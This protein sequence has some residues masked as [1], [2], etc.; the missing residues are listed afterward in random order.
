[1]LISGGGVSLATFVGDVSNETGVLIDVIV[2]DLFL[3]IGKVDPVAALDFVAITIL[4]LAHIS[5][6][7]VIINVPAEFV[8]SGML[9]KIKVKIVCYFYFF[10]LTLRCQT[11]T[12]VSGVVLLIVALVVRV[13]GDDS[14]DG[15]ENNSDLL[16][17]K[18]YNCS[19]AQSCK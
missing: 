9:Y 15:E 11:Y 16:D 19:T 7:V 17:I 12:I 8:V 5:V 13:G 6:I 3:S 10:F 18:A 2:D 1:M 4:L 14:N